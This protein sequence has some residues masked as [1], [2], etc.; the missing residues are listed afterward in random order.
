[1]SRLHK[2]ALLYLVGIVLLVGAGF[3]VKHIANARSAE[4]RTE[5]RALKAL[6]EAG[7]HT[8]VAQAELSPGERRVELQGEARPY[9][10]VTLYA[11]LS[12]YLKRI[13]VDRGD[14]VRA[15]Q[16]LAEIESPELDRQYDA[17]TADA[18]YR[19]ASAKRAATLVG[20][21]VVSANEADLESSRAAVAE[22]QVAALATQRSY[23]AIHAPFAGIITAR[24]ADPGALVQ[25]AANAQTSALPIVTVAQPE[26]LR[27]YVYVG[28]RDASYIKAGDLAEVSMPDR[29]AL[30]LRGRVA[31]TS[32]Q[33][34]LR[35]RTLLVEI[36]LDNK[37]GDIVP[38]SFVS[39]TLVVRT[40]R[41][42]EVP[43]EAL[44]V[45]GTQTLVAVV[46]P[47]HTVHYRRVVLAS[48]DGTR[49]RIQSGLGVGEL[50]ALNLGDS[51]VDGALV[52]P[53]QSTPQAAPAAPP[54]KPAPPAQPVPQ[55]GAR[56]S[57]R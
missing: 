40:P 48:D 19:Q 23:Q 54:A 53:V 45:R 17:A 24:F 10:S 16:L 50:V 56:G 2:P 33:L 22:A 15:G 4:T 3:G 30:K 52:Q 5:A 20:P 43:V 18:R 27:I 37:K 29:P 25:N 13:L 42:V 49:A 41:E 9:Q 44:V 21:G 11:K 35:T 28:Q 34:D 57:G 47:D 55:D 36:D 7:P 26:R 31:R 12:G 8:I 38:G 39:V 51:V 1:M 6:V 14:R 32:G 46:S